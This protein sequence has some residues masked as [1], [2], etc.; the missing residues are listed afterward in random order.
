MTNSIFEKSD[1]NEKLHLV[2]EEYNSAI[3]NDT[4]PSAEAKD[5]MKSMFDADL[6]EAFEYQSVM[7]NIVD[8]E[9]A[10]KLQD[11]VFNNAGM[12]S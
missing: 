9:T 10:S 2:V 5:I 3:D 1:F 7:E 8:K 12:I 6:E 11:I 4:E